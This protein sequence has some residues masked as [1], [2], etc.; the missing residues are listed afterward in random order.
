MA[1]STDND[2]IA[3]S[4]AYG[5]RILNKRL[6]R[7]AFTAQFVYGPKVARPSM[8]WKLKDESV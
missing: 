5:S 2:G 4:L 1:D 8:I 3:V 6:Q 7:K